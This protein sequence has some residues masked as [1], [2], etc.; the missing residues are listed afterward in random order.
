MLTHAGASEV[1]VEFSIAREASSLTIADNGIGMD[2]ESFR[3]NWLRPGFSQKSPDYNGPRDT[4]PVAQEA[5]RRA[6]NREPSGEKGLG[7]LASGRLGEVLEV[8][9]RRTARDSWLHVTFNWAEFD[10]MQQYMDEIDIP[11]DQDPPDEAPFASGTI[12]RIEGL[13]QNWGGRAGDRRP[14]ES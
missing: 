3:T 2:E 6:S 11:Y 9:T 7:R 10:D 8:W 12:I 1:I 4:R 13:R 14:A 5:E